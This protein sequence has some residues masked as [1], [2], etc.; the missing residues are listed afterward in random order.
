MERWQERTAI[1]LGE[2]RLDAF[3]AKIF[4]S[5]RKKDRALARE[6]MRTIHQDPLL[7]DVAIWYD[8][9][10]T[11]GED[12]N[13]EIGSTI[14]YIRLTKGGKEFRMYKFRSMCPNAEDKLEELLDQLNAV[15]GVAVPRRLADLKNKT[16]RFDLTAEKQEM[17]DVVLN[18]LK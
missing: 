11:L 3:A 12:F 7:R 18:F 17:D 10:L 6:L 14:G 5:Y 8:E 4:L 9:F 2:E 16:R 13:A 15:S 1:L